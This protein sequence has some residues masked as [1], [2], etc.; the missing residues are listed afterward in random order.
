[1]SLG[2][3][4]GLM[5]LAETIGMLIAFRLWVWRPWAGWLFAMTVPMLLC[6]MDGHYFWGEHSLFGLLPN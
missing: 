2:F 6:V 3:Q 5:S 4:A 1:M